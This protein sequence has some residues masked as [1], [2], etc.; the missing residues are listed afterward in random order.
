MKLKVEESG[1]LISPEDYIRQ[2]GYVSY[3]SLSNLKKGEM[4]EIRP[5]SQ[6]WHDVGTEI[7]SRFLESTVTKKFDLT[8]EA[9]LDG[10]ERSLRKDK[11]VDSLISH[12][13]YTTEK[14]FRTKLDGV[15]VVGYVDM[16]AA[17]IFLADLKSIGHRNEKKFIESMDFLQPALYCKV[18][19]VRDF[20]YIGI[21]KIAPYEVF[22]F[23]V[24]QYPER[25]QQACNELDKLLNHVKT[26]ILTSKD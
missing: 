3:S 11:L 15:P 10:M 18:R 21:S 1:D 16:D 7:H 5:K 4:L 9:M 19:R 13:L 14:E 2:R 24:N 26:K 23:N 25:F 20:Y 6:V 8:T 17:P 22:T 12:S